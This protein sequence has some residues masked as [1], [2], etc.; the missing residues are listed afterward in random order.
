MWFEKTILVLHF[1]MVAIAT[2]THTVI[3]T[4]EHELHD[5]QL[6]LYYGDSHLAT[7]TQSAIQN[8][9]ASI[10]AALC[11]DGA[12]ESHV[13]RVKNSHDV[14]KDNGSTYAYFSTAS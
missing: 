5:L 2:Y 8:Y 13:I 12:S 10:R 3:V 4:S 14:F 11:S 6:V 7:T 1:C 9:A